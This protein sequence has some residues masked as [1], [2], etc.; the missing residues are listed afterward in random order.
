MNKKLIILGIIILFSFT[1]I[2]AEEFGYNYLEN[3]NKLINLDDVLI[4]SPIEEQILLYNSS[5]GLWYNGYINESGHDVNNSQY[6]RGLTPQEVADLYQELWQENGD[7][8]YY[9][10]G[11][12]GIGTS[13]PSETLEVSNDNDYSTLKVISTDSSSGSFFTQYNNNNEYLGIGT[14]GSANA[15]SDLFGLSRP[16]NQFIFAT[17]NLAI[18]TLS[19]ND[20]ILGTANIERVRIDYEGN[21]GI[22]TDNPSRK[23]EVYDASSNVY[24]ELNTDNI[25]GYA[26]LEIGND[27]QYWTTG[28]DSL[29]RY[30]VNNGVQFSGNDSIV[31][32]A[33]GPDSQL[34]LDSSGNVGIGTS[35][36]GSAIS[37][38]TTGALADFYRNSDSGATFTIRNNEISNFLRSDSNYFTVNNVLYVDSSSNVGVGI[39]SPSE[40]LHVSAGNFTM[41]SGYYLKSGNSGIEF[42]D[43][44]FGNEADDLT[45]YA[46]GG[47]EFIFGQNGAVKGQI[48][49]NGFIFDDDFN[50]RDSS[51]DSIFYVN[52]TSESVGIGTSTPSHE[53]NVVGDLNV[54]GIIYGNG[55]QL[56]DLN[57]SQINYWSKNNTNLYYNDGNIGIGTSNPV[58]KLEIFG[59]EEVLLNITDENG[60]FLYVN[61]SSGDLYVS[62][63][64]FA[65]EFIVTNSNSIFFGRN[66]AD[67]DA[68]MEANTVDYGI[69]NRSGITVEGVNGSGADFG[70]VSFQNNTLLMSAWNRND[71]A[72]AG[73]DLSVANNVLSKYGTLVLSS[74]HHLY[75]NEGFF[76][77]R[78]QKTSLV[79]ASTEGLSLSIADGINGYQDFSFKDF[80]N[81]TDVITIGNRTDNYL[82]TFNYDVNFSGNQNVTG[83]S[84]YGGNVTASYFF[85]NG[86][87]LTNI[88]KSDVNYWIKNNTDLY[89]NEGNVGIGTS[90]PSTS[91]HIKSGESGATGFGFEDEIIIEGDFSVGMN[92]LS[93]NMT[94]SGI[95]FSVSDDNRI[96]DLLWNG[97]NKLLSLG[98][99]TTNGEI[100]FNTGNLQ[101]AMRID[102]DGNVGI[103]TTTPSSELEI[104]ST[105]PKITLNDYD[106]AGSRPEIN[107]INNSVLIF[108]NDDTQLSAY[109]FYSESSNNRSYDAIMRI[110]GKEASG[111]SNYL[112]LRH[113]GDGGYGSITTA[114]GDLVLNSNSGKIGVGVSSPSV[115]FQVNDTFY[116]DATSEKVGIG[117]SSPSSKLDI[118]GSGITSDPIVNINGDSLTTGNL[119][120][121]ESNA[122]NTNGRILNYFANAN[123]SATGTEVMRIYQAST[124]PALAIY[125]ESESTSAVR[126]EA[127]AL[128]TGNGLYVISD[129]NDT[130][131]RNLVYFHNDDP[132]STETIG[133][134]V[135]QDSSA[136]A[137][138]FMGDVGVNTDSPNAR[139]EINASDVTTGNIL[140]IDA[141]NLNSG[142]G[143]NIENSELVN[144]G[145]LIRAYTDTA[146]LS[147]ANM[148]EIINEDGGSGITN[149]FLQQNADDEALTINATG[150]MVEYVIDVYGTDKLTTGGLLKL[151]SNSNDTS[152]RN[153]FLINNSNSNSN[154]AT[155]LYVN[156]ES[157]AP[158]AVFMGDVGIGLE[159]PSDTFHVNGS[160]RIANTGDS[161]YVRFISG[162][163]QL[164]DS[165]GIPRII[166]NP[167]GDSYIQEGRFGI[168]D[169]SPEYVL[170]VAGN[171]SLNNTFYVNNDGNVGIGTD[172][173]SV[174]LETDGNVKL[175]ARGITGNHEIARYD[176]NSS[177]YSQFSEILI[178][179]SQV[180]IASKNGTGTGTYNGIREFIVDESRTDGI[181]ISD[182][183]T[184]R[185]LV[186]ATANYNSTLDQWIPHKKYVDDT[187]E[188]ENL[189]EESATFLSPKSSKG[190]VLEQNESDR[191]I[192]ITQN[193]DNEAIFISAPGVE[194][195]PV[196]TISSSNDDSVQGLANF[197]S[198]SASPWSRALIKIHQDNSGAPSSTGLYIVQDSDAPAI[199]SDGDIKKHKA[200]YNLK[201][202]WSFIPTDSRNISDNYLG[203]FDVD[204]GT[205]VIELT[206]SGSNH[207]A[208]SKFEVVKQYGPSQVPKVTALEGSFYSDYTIYYRNINGDTYE[209][210]WDTDSNDG[211]TISYVAWITHQSEIT[212]SISVSNDTDI[213]A[214]TMAL[215]T[216]RYGVG[217]ATTPSVRF[218]VN[219][220]FYVTDSGYVGIGT[221]SPTAEL[222]ISNGNPGIVL[223]DEDGGGS[224]PQINIKNNALLAFTNDDT[225]T[226][227]WDFTSELTNN[228]SYDALVRIYGNEAAGWSNYLALTHTGNDGKISTAS[229]DLYL[230][231]TSGYIGIGTPSPTEVLDVDGNINVGVGQSGIIDKIQFDDNAN[232]SLISFSS[233]GVTPPTS[234]AGWKLKLWDVGGTTTDYGLGV[235]GST[236][237]MHTGGDRIEF[238]DSGSEVMIIDDGQVGIGKST[239]YSSGSNNPP[240]TVKVEGDLGPGGLLVEGEDS[241]DD[242]GSLWTG[243]AGVY[244]A[245]TD[246]EWS[247]ETH[248]GFGDGD[249]SWSFSSD[250]NLKR[251]IENITN[252][253]DKINSIRGVNF[254]WNDSSKNLHETRRTGV[255]AQEIQ[256]IMPELVSEGPDGYLAV[257]YSGFTPYLIEA[258]K[259]LKAENDLLRSE[260]C[261]RDVTYSWC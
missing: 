3:E 121:S 27:A 33:E 29:D 111:Y 184:N 79:G 109:D 105:S 257:G 155:G 230:E 205:V 260:L 134:Y 16:N 65:Q 88:N 188:S 37:V 222:E 47:G 183:I 118:N 63:K 93:S 220:T 114:S 236:L 102:S 39:D 59:S 89:Y 175:I 107:V 165:S 232:G 77:G 69:K 143:I 178:Y 137:A 40:K 172:S 83:S 167:N 55:S 189:W 147:Q 87:Y 22:G 85:G 119:I 256:P 17:N 193:T 133:L 9:N 30:V 76:Y 226:A 25:N 14:Y 211:T 130:S 64:T 247:T 19:S 10:D 176:T 212:D 259:E 249:T 80:T 97:N 174:K 94:T 52:R 112:Q 142:K 250:E 141:T 58:G 18:G 244:V 44:Q 35:T 177:T 61:G 225:T 223:N 148:V 227:T 229:G 181:Y 245:F 261:K 117:I 246:D 171:T 161:G 115:T 215:V 192:Y 242:V 149:L 54:T 45:L 218:Q 234:E 74:N 4:S 81:L 190:I 169:T 228:R 8:I 139:L 51:Y 60:H 123:P 46:G 84:T 156:Q 95:V 198:D 233:T 201:K 145:S 113:T 20:F 41:D 62:G 78:G 191:G 197:Y 42:G 135:Q 110:Y 166:F 160:M 213:N 108:S 162:T 204:D 6:L 13:A 96:A 15:L 199:D 75:P 248:A 163:L 157:S 210:F 82:T 92:I 24:I 98:T 180:Y 34:Y 224:R 238:W 32:E 185:G 116:V 129:S 231:S 150:V 239:P 67:F 128:T 253:L 66:I 26:G 126:I 100:Q 206:D 99:G 90:N 31:V 153:L 72:Y 182:S 219:E 125:A 217:I 38:E 11:N 146:G 127:D 106:D 254:N 132:L 7:D 120:Y 138:V 73:A 243:S 240:L 209:L 136:P 214:A 104:K 23:L 57:K 154:S 170:D 124:D 179:P 140:D 202:T 195:D 56:T 68:K 168:L 144:G 196:M 2:S 21:V 235:D 152:N 49:N 158:S 251:D 101:N 207:G 86:S 91:L 258:V 43:G 159:S 71:S 48:T 186:Y 151:Q 103:G 208:S 12:V 53:L 122:A 187:I 255:I 216:N 194:S 237:W 252:A 36:P 70:L 1:I 203:T 164:A 241:S 50:V 221:S 173:P 131:T 200:I 5:S 28:V